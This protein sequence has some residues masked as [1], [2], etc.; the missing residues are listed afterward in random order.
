MSKAEKF[1]K[2]VAKFLKEKGWGVLVIG[3]I[4]IEQRNPSRKYNFELVV[5]F[6]GKKLEKKKEK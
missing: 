3:G 1:Y 4:R 2:E 5:N 6:T